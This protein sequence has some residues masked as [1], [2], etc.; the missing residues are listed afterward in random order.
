MQ[1]APWQHPIGLRIPI[2]RVS[3]R[4]SKFAPQTSDLEEAVWAAILRARLECAH[5][6]ANRLALAL[7]LEM[8]RQGRAV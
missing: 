3:S 6:L 5:A 8:V 2:R 1:P 4:M 7:A